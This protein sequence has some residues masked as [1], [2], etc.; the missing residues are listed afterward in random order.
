MNVFS[1]SYENQLNFIRNLMSSEIND[2]I[3]INNVHDKA[4][5]DNQS[6]GFGRIEADILYA[7]IRSLKPKK[8]VQIGCGVSTAICIN[9]SKFSDY[10]PHILCIEPYP[11]NYL[12]KQSHNK[13]IEL[14]DKHF[15]LLDFS[16]ICRLFSLQKF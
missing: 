6:D 10:C 16:I 9:A 3:T 13:N 12:I 5:R 15:E 7:F 11:N 8:I 2:E 1:E 4:I 14:I